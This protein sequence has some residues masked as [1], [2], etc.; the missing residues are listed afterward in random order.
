[1]NRLL[2]LLILLATPPCWAKDEPQPLRLEDFAYGMELKVSGGSPVVS[3]S[4]PAEVYKG[5]VR[6]DLG[7]LRVFNAQGPVPHLLRQPQPEQKENPAQELPFFPLSAPAGA[8]RAADFGIAI[9]GN[10]TLIAISAGGA[11]KAVQTVTAYLID[12]S[13]LQHRPNWLDFAWQGQFSA[14]VQLDS[15]DDLNSWQP[16]TSA[17]LAELSFGGHKLL[18]NRIDLNQAA[19]GKYLR[20]SW[21]PGK[22]GISLSAVKAGYESETRTQPRTLLT[23]VGQPDAAAAGH[24]AWFY[25][26]DGF[27]PIDQLNIRLPEQNSLAEFAVFSRADEKAAWQQRASLLAWRLT[28]NGVN[29]ENGLL[30]LAPNADRYWRLEIEGNGSQVPKLE[31]GWLPGQLIFMAQ[32]E[33]PYSLVYGRAGL[34]PAHSQVAQ[35]IKAVEP[36]SGSKLI[37][38]AKA[39]AQTVLAG[40]TAL[41][42]KTELPWRIWLLW[43]GLI[44]GVLAV[45]AMALK[46]FKEMNSTR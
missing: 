9:G 45:G 36:V 11:E 17:A 35:L 12:I 15:S 43:A 27:F 14:S 25:M 33:G 46:L 16:V 20:L 19:T 8:N 26:T 6:P 41:A 28:V 39:G 7:D 37:E 44:A 23:L 1:M 31:L 2:I 40:Q 32:G 5:C 18:R 29:L 22:D 38:A 10:G 4:L 21:S 3:L 13:A 34:L 24:A 42:P 30:H